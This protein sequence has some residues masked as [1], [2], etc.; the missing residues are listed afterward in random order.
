MLHKSK[1]TLIELLV[2]IAIIAILA[3][4]LLPALQSARER[5]R[6]ASC[7][8][9]MKQLGM[10]F[11]Q[12]ATNHN[13]WCITGR[14]VNHLD[15]H[16]WFTL[17]EEYKLINKEVTRCPSSKYWNFT[18]REL[19]YGLQYFIFSG[20]GGGMKLSSQYLKYPARTMVF[21]DSKP[22]SKFKEEG[23]G[24][25]KF[26]YIVGQFC[27]DDSRTSYPTEFRH[28]R[29]MMTVQLDG[30]VQS[31]IPVQGEARCITCPWYYHNNSS[32]WIACADPHIN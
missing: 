6:T 32:S 15:K 28:N 8:N 9:N 26:S 22:N 7:T 25:N 24:E 1:F 31:I 29:K 5:G 11:I 4:I 27:R 13:E 30:H 17:F 20:L 18:F 14:D 12:Y 10:A 16:H 3:A 2:V 19:N 21:G 23:Y